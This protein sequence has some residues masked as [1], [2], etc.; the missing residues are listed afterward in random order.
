MFL[1]NSRPPHVNAICAYQ[2][3][4]WLFEN[5]RHY[6][7]DFP[8]LGSPNTPWLFQPASPVLVLGT[9]RYD[10]CVFP[11]HGLKNSAI[12]VHLAA[13]P[14]NETPQ[15]FALLFKPILKRQEYTLRCRAYV[16]GA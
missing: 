11:F 12:L 9:D 3:Q 7:A 2:A 6:F 16:S 14:H 4:T 10:R 8:N 13:S 15:P 5:L 1:I